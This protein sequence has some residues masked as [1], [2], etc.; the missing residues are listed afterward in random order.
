M[1][2]IVLLKDK[3]VIGLSCLECFPVI[4]HPWLNIV[5]SA[6]LSFLV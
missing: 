1:L 6:A 5:L 2:F 3:I 4:L